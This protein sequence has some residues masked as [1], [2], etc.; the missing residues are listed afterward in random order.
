MNAMAFRFWFQCSVIL[1][2]IAVLV[3]AM[4]QLGSEGGST[5]ACA[6]V[7]ERHAQVSLLQPAGRAFALAA[8]IC[9][10]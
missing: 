10:L 2:T 1:A 7:P 8:R 6:G 4:I 5:G 3:L 9:G